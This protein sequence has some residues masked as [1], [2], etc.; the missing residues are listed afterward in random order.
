[1]KKEMGKFDREIQCLMVEG[2]FKR[3]SGYGLI[4][5]GAFT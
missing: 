4:S 5:S 1:M 2:R 3:K